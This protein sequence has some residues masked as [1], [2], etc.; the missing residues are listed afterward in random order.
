[1]I[2]RKIG[3]SQRFGGSSS[4]SVE[5]DCSSGPLLL[6]GGLLVRVQPE[7]PI[8]SIICGG[9]I[10]RPIFT[11]PF[12]RPFH[13]GFSLALESSRM[14]GH[15]RSL[16]M[17]IF[18]QPVHVQY[19]PVG[20]GHESVFT[21]PLRRSEPRQNSRRS[22]R[23]TNPLLTVAKRIVQTRRTTFSKGRRSTGVS[24]RF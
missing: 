1:M 5:C 4:L 18:S 2:A 20:E 19:D 23:Q 9:R 15:R 10:F 8:F 24:N 17:L 3:G 12:P 6:T 14:L 11:L 22:R 7:E 13:A 21:P 16:F